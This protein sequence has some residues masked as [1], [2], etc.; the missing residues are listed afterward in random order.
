[1]RPRLGELVVT[2]LATIGVLSALLVWEIEHVGSVLLALVLAI[3]GATVGI[4]VARGV[5]RQI[6]ELSRY[7]ER[8]LETADE[9]SRRAETANQMKDEFLATV[10]HEL[11]TPLNSVLGW[12]RLLGA[13]KLDANQYSKAVQAIERAGWAQSRL[14]EDLLDSPESSAANSRSRRALWLR[15]RSSK[16]QSNRSGQRQPRRKLP[17]TFP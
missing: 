2:P 11:R 9:E 6:D 10:S 17:S 8:L 3:V 7:Y 14:I 1:M 5:R 16:P 15:S 12:A 13:G 4:F